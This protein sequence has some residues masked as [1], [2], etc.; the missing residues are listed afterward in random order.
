MNILTIRV[1]HSFEIPG[2][3]ELLAEAKLRELE[4]R[5][6]SLV[7]D[8]IT[9][10]NTAVDA[11]LARVQEDVETLNTTIAE[12]QAKVDQGLATPEEIAALEGAIAKVNALDPVS[13]ETLPEEPPTP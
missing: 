4:E 1:V 11:A 7:G 3:A 13:P 10:L 2:L 9:E 5:I 12:L 6:M 8:K